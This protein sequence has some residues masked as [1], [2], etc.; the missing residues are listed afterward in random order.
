MAWAVRGRAS[1][2]FGPSV[3]HGSRD[4][5]SI[6]LTFDD[7]PSET[8]PRLLELL[9]RHGV[10]ATFFVCG[11][12][13]ARLPDA[14]REIAAAGHEIGNHSYSHTRFDFHS[15]AFIYD[16]LS[17]AQEVIGGAAGRVPSLFRSPYGVRWFGLAEVQR[18]LKLLGVMWTALGLDWRLD[19][20]RICSRLERRAAPGS[21]FCLHDGR[22]IQVRPDVRATID[23]VGRL[24]PILQ[25]KGFRF[26]T[27][28]EILCPKQSPTG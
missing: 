9:A 21:I 28:S 18:R 23:A 24:I 6:A 1:R 8:T 17:R 13:V 12:N 4:R 3:W 27:V 20:G 7:G 25:E 22:D 16:E 10:R 15:R 2:I 26:E 11:A 14:A 19:A 5:R